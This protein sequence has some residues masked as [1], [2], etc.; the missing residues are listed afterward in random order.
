MN[1]TFL[2]MVLV[3]LAALMIGT[4]LYFRH[5]W[6]KKGLGVVLITW[7]AVVSNISGTHDALKKLAPYV[8]LN[9]DSAPADQTPPPHSEPAKGTVGPTPFAP[10][11]PEPAGPPPDGLACSND[12]IVE[13]SSGRTQLDLSRSGLIRCLERTDCER[14]AASV[15]TQAG[16]SVDIAS[17]SRLSLSRLSDNDRRELAVQFE[18]RLCFR[19]A[20]IW[21]VGT[22]TGDIKAG[23]ARWKKKVCEA[24]RSVLLDDSSTKQTFSNFGVSDP[25]YNRE[26]PWKTCVAL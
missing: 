16:A 26:I 21:I 8:G 10:N 15:C 24:G 2:V 6:F 12:L 11:R 9:L 5:P 13:E 7:A 14:A 19:E 22:K 1:N 17:C 4:F 3:S 25:S 20:L 23:L 18:Q